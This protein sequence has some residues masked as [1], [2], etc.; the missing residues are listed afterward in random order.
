MNTV[1]ELRPEK[2]EQIMQQVPNYI[3]ED[4]KRFRE[5]RKLKNGLFVEVNL[6][7]RQI[8]QLCVE[9]LEIIGLSAEDF[10]VIAKQ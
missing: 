2:F 10:V 6:N 8:Q 3:G 1:F 5:V 7:A 9:V 4:Q